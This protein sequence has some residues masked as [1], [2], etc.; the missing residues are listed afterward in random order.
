VHVNETQYF[1]GIAPEV[2]NYYIGGYQVLNKWLK[3][4][5]DRRLSAEDIKHYTRIATALFH[6]I[7]I[8]AQIDKLYS[9]AENNIL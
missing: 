8:Q 7:T 2:W 4:R 1:E 9:K 5:K 6:T 3:D